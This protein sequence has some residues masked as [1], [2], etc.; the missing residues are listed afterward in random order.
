MDRT[1]QP[2]AS[3][4]IRTFN[5]PQL[6]R[7]AVESVAKQ[8]WRNLELVVA[9][10]AG[11]DVSH[12]L[13]EFRDQFEKPEDLVYMT[14]SE[15]DKPGRCIAGNLAVEAST[16]D[17]IFYLDDDDFYY[18]DHVEALVTAALEHD[19]KILYSDAKQGW[20]EPI[21]ENGA[22][23]ITAVKDGMSEDFSKAAFYVGT[24]IHISTFCHHRSI[25]DELG[26]FDPEVELLEDLDLYFRYA[27]NYEF[28]HVARYTAQFQIRSDFTN[29]VTAMRKEYN[30]QRERICKKY[31]HT[32]IRDLLVYIHDGRG[33]VEKTRMELAAAEERVTM[34]EGMA[35]ERVSTLEKRVAE[36]E[37]A[38]REARS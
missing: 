5:R 7:R 2:R 31:L 33:Q 10:D 32:V 9:N 4:I 14:W 11:E 36:L 24:Y 29:A 1:E 26:G 17:W 35:E 8:S 6:L 18:E 22:Y 23:V 34:L 21:G 12:I 13:E 25:Y 16:G 27:Q 20:E 15:A 28:H 30:E 19:A 38:L 3:V 37:A